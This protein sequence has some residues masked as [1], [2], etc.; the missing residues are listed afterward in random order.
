MEPAL[1]KNK[2]STFTQ[3]MKMQTVKITILGTGNIGKSSLTYK[4]LKS[5]LPDGGYDPTIEDI[6]KTIKR[7]NNKDYE[8][9][10]MDTAGQDDHQGFLD[11]WI[12]FADAF[13]LVFSL[14]DSRS[15]SEID[16]RRTKILE[17]KK[18]PPMI[19]V[20]NK[21]D[22]DREVQRQDAED[23]AK[24]WGVKYMETS[25][26]KEINCEE[27]FILL[28]KEYLLSKEADNPSKDASKD[29]NADSKREER[30]SLRERKRNNGCNC[31]IF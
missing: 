28:V 8:I 25:A 7:V 4:F 10:I 15:F 19:L 20:G 21:C 1:D 13:V 24:S 23:K 5:K 2:S 16:H 14:D 26:L 31:E 22:V 11:N 27:I 30:N 29:P 3:K 9:K 12:E 18:N 17:H 6:Y